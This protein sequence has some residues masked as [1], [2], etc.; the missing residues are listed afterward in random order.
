MRVTVRDLMT[1]DPVT[2]EADSTI[3]LAL[4]LVLDQALNEVYV[5][6]TEGQLEGIVSDYALLKA[7]LNQ[8][9]VDRPVTQIMSRALMVLSP[10]ATLE[11]VAGLFREGCHQRVAVVENGRIIGQLSRRDVLRALIVVDDVRSDVERHRRFEVAEPSI[12]RPHRPQMYSTEGLPTATRLEFR[13]AGSDR[14]SPRPFDAAFH[15]H[16]TEAKASG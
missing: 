7:R 9:D 3:G 4:N 1:L 10:N 13:D 11:E 8:C 12:S 6:D 14:Y 15:T 2:I 16:G 5:R